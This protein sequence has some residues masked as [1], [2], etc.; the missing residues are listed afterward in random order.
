MGKSKRTRVRK[1]PYEDSNGMDVETTKGPN[2][3]FSVHDITD[4]ET[5]QID[6]TKLFVNMCDIR[7]DNYANAT[8][9]SSLMKLHRIENKAFLKRKNDL[10]EIM[11]GVKY[12]S[13]LYNISPQEQKIG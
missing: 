2:R 9:L 11:Y 3:H 4:P 6:V 1:S 7:E 12:I 10:K 13:F 5:N 8:S